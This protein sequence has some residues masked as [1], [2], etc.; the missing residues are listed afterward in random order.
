MYRGNNELIECWRV[1][2]SGDNSTRTY[3]GGD[4]RAN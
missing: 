3:A 2:S 4:G 1:T